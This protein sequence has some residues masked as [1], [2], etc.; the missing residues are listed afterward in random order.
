[1]RG[2]A[3]WK[4]R[5]DPVTPEDLLNHLRARLGD[6]MG[7]AAWL[8]LDEALSGER[9]YWPRSISRALRARAAYEMRSNGQSITAVCAR[10][11]LSR[12]SVHRLV[13]AELLR[14]RRT[15]SQDLAKTG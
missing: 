15:M 12:A 9:L 8:I 2:E 4:V 7:Q 5:H 6:E 14:R 13:K 1:M 10:L 3:R 11:N